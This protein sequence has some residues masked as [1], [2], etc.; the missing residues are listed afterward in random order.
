MQVLCDLL[1]S[2]AGGSALQC[3]AN[4]ETLDSFSVNCIDW[5]QSFEQRPGG[6]TNTGYINFNELNLRFDAFE[7]GLVSVDP[8]RRRRID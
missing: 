4:P 7:H 2:A 8:L 5:N 3:N 1:L 6:S